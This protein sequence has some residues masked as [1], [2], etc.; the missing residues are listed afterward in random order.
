M[1]KYNIRCSRLLLLVMMLLC[2]ALLHSRLASF[3]VLHNQTIDAFADTLPQQL[4][5]EFSVQRQGQALYLQGPVGNAEV[6]FDT[7]VGWLRFGSIALRETVEAVTSQGDVLQLTPEGEAITV[8]INHRDGAS[9]LLRATNKGWLKHTQ[10]RWVALQPCSAA[11][12]AKL[13]DLRTLWNARQTLDVGGALWCRNQAGLDNLSVQLKLHYSQQQWWLEPVASGLTINHSNQW[14]QVLE[15]KFSIAG[16]QIELGE[17]VVFVKRRTLSSHTESHTTESNQSAAANISSSWRAVLPWADYHPYRL[18]GALLILAMLA[19]LMSTTAQLIALVFALVSFLPMMQS[20]MLLLVAL[21]AQLLTLCRGWRSFF[22]FTLIIFGLTTQWLNAGLADDDWLFAQHVV[23]QTAL[24]A[25]LSMVQGAFLLRKFAPIH[26]A[27]LMNWLWQKRTKLFAFLMVTVIVLSTVAMITGNETGIGSINV[28][29]IL[30]ILIISCC[31]YVVLVGLQ[32][33]W[34][35]NK[36]F[37]LIMLAII[38]L[39]SLVFGLFKVGENSGPLILLPVCIVSVILLAA[40]GTSR[41][42]ASLKKL[43]WGIVIVL[44]TMTTLIFYVAGNWLHS[45][46]TL[47][48][49]LLSS[50]IPAS[51]RIAAWLF[52][53]AALFDRAQ[54]DA[55]LA[56]SGAASNWPASTLLPVYVP[57]HAHDMAVNA[58]TYLWGNVLLIGFLTLLITLLVSGAY[59]AV[60]TIKRASVAQPGQSLQQRQQLVLLGAMVVLTQVAIFTQLTISLGSNWGYTPLIGQPMPFISFALSNFICLIFPA[61]LVDIYLHKLLREKSC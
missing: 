43:S 59:R 32:H 37:L 60:V 61:I 8:R 10:A 20:G 23:F 53:E 56:L 45:E 19:V 49:T 33:N 29:E 17:Q 39:F 13:P 34:T 9:S 48:N 12:L 36:A 44:M 57:A 35:Y 47:A 24:L 22:W 40:L 58:A 28:W 38:A 31:A 18:V 26:S 52:P 2:V 55:A 46:Q 25:V 50:N 7:N 16:Q 54:L 1:D 51:E 3:Q 4:P 41:Q 27:R 21:A 5:S 30:R 11:W 15:G 42:N 6:Q 14:Q